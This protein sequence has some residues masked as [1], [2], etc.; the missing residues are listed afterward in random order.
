MMNS[1]FLHI[2][3]LELQKNSCLKFE[4]MIINKS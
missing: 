2:S 3:Y 1:D 4:R